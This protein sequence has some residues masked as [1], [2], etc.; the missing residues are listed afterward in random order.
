MKMRFPLAVLFMSLAFGCAPQ[1]PLTPEEKAQA[2]VDAAYAAV[3]ASLATGR[4]L[5]RAEFAR[6]LEAIAA[7]DLA[8]LLSEKGNGGWMGEQRML[9]A[10]LLL[11]GQCFERDAAKAA[12]LL[13]AALTDDPYDEDWLA[14]LGGLYWR[15]EG[16]PVD[17][18]RARELFHRAA[19]VLGPEE[20]N[21]NEAAR[22]LRVQSPWHWGMDPK[23]YEYRFSFAAPYW[24]PD[25]LPPPLQEEVDWLRDIEA[26]S[27]ERVFEIAQSLLE[28]KNGYPK[29]IVLAVDW[30]HLADIEFDYDAAT[31]PLAMLLRDP[32]TYAVRAKYGLTL[33]REMDLRTANLALRSAAGH[34]DTRGDQLILDL[35]LRAPD[36]PGK[37]KAVYYWLLRLDRQGLLAD[38]GRLEAAA[39]KL[40]YHLM[41]AMEI[42]KSPPVTRLGATE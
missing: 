3:E 29:D 9:E 28:G 18:K 14:R 21:P 27:G 2:E 42:L 38:R 40:P 32:N 24:P 1:K 4:R 10:E 41:R 37:D 26:G 12:A 15:G 16:V 36:Y 7:C 19:L 33:S 23:G 39:A 8:E 20:I 11:R 34:G 31:Y 25:P 6:H 17:K 13:E 22:M 35:L 5:M 30:L